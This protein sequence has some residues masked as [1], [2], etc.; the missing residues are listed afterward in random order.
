LQPPF[1]SRNQKEMYDKTL[2]QP[3]SIPDSASHHVR[4][5]LTEM[6]RKHR[7][8]RWEKFLLNKILIN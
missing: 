8:E 1:Y 7:L 5:L 6:L 4:D 2:H 3:L